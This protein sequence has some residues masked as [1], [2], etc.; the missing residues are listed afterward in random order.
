MTD[1]TIAILTLPF[2]IALT[3]A[4]ECTRIGCTKLSQRRRAK[5]EGAASVDGSRVGAGAE[6]LGRPL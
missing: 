4:L 6:S 5:R 3:L 1:T 2:L